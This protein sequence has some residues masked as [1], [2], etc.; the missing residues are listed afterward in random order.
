MYWR[1]SEKHLVN[2]FDLRANYYPLLVIR[3][4]C[5]LF[6]SEKKEKLLFFG[7]CFTLYESQRVYWLRKTHIRNAIKPLYDAV[8]GELNVSENKISSYRRAYV[9]SFRPLAAAYTL[10]LTTDFQPA[11]LCQMFACR[12]HS[13]SRLLTFFFTF[14]YILLFSLALLHAF[15]SPFFLA[16]SLYRRNFVLLF[17]IFTYLFFFF[18]ALAFIFFVSL[19]LSIYLS[20]YLSIYHSMY[21]SLYLSSVALTC[22]DR[23]FLASEPDSDANRERESGAEEALRSVHVRTGRY[24]A[25]DTWSNRVFIR[26]VMRLNHFYWFTLRVTVHVQRYAVNVRSS[27]DWIEISNSF[28]RNSNN[29]RDFRNFTLPQRV[30]WAH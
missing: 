29:S 23:E 30:F 12:H 15:I 26:H 1:G 7:V 17:R 6:A 16:S 18:C 21:L 10:V 27:H 25:M 11:I 9:S 4:N 28:Y 24:A 22:S 20:S 19:Y 5:L 3:C 14:S 13:R 8:C 2:C